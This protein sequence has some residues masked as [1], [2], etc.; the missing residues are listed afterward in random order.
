[1]K[2]SNTKLLDSFDKY[3][4]FIITCHINADGDAIGAANALGLYLE[5]KGKDVVVIYPEEI[6]EK[7]KFLPGPKKIEI[8]QK[9]HSSDKKETQVLIALDSSDE[10]RIET[11][12]DQVDY[13]VL[14]NID[15]HPTNTFF[16]DVNVVEPEKSATCQLLYD[17]LES[18]QEMDLDIGTNLY[19]G[20]LTDTGS[21]GFENTDKKTFET[22]A[23]LVGMGVKSH[24][25]SREIY[26]TLPVKTFYFIRELLNTLEITN[27]YRIAWL[28]CSRD[29]MNKYEVGAGELEG[30]INFPKN[31]KPV[32][33]ALL[34]KETEEGN[35]KVGMRSKDYDVGK[36]A[37]EYYGGGHKR[38]AGCLLALPLEKAKKEIIK[39]LQRELCKEALEIE[40]NN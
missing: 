29:L 6:P 23:K 28:T 14:I 26:E 9:S 30:V 39:R 36:I 21:F 15:H 38:A 1:M 22:A 3:N 20:I 5:K 27:D 37:K 7:Y 35:T 32:E 24:I 31:L 8:I 13:E 19:A 4:K 40:G 2:M 34:F 10:V 11:V 17:L 16:G 33:F 25:V 18:E 12:K